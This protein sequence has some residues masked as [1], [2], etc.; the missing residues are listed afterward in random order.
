MLKF[1]TKLGKEGA[2]VEVDIGPMQVEPLTL[3]G[4]AN[5][6]SAIPDHEDTLRRDRGEGEGRKVAMRRHHHTLKRLSFDGRAL[7]H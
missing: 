7:P 6:R 4:L 1:Q 2:Q 3:D 5:D